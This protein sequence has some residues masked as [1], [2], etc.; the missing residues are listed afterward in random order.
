MTRLEAGIERRRHRAGR[1]ANDAEATTVTPHPASRSGR[2]D[3][4]QGALRDA[5][6]ALQKLD[7]RG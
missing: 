2:D 4:L 7:A 6:D 3:E 1:A 5:L